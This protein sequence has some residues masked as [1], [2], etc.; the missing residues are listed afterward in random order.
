M[1]RPITAA[2]WAS[3]FWSV[4]RVEPRGEEV[5]DR[6]RDL[7]RRRGPVGRAA[8]RLR[9]LLG[10]QGIAVAARADDAPEILGDAVDPRELLDEPA[11]ILVG[12]RAQ[13]DRVDGRAEWR[14]VEVR[15]RRRDDEERRRG[16]DGD[17]PGQQLQRRLVGPLDVFDEE[18]RVARARPRR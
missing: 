14:R 7:V 15:A 5:A 13:R 9:Q 6:T 3:G 10:E 12:Q 11:M 18:E 1:S 4:E 17:E 2:A 16:L 8:D